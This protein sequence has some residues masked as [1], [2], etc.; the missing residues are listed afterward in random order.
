LIKQLPD[1]MTLFKQEL[2]RKNV[3]SYLMLFKDNVRI[4][5]TLVDRENLTD[6][7]QSDSLTMVLLDKDNLFTHINL[8]SEKDYFI[9]KPDQKRF[10]DCCNEFW[11]VST[12]VAKGL[13][14]N[15]ITYAKDMLEKP[16]RDMF[17]KMIEWYIGVKT[18]FTVSFGKSGKNMKKY[19]PLELYQRILQ[20]YPDH[21]IDNIWN[22][23][24]LMIDIFRNIQKEVS[25]MLGLKYDQTEE[26]NVIEYL[27]I[28]RSKH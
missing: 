3:F 27:K 8:P 25:D 20:T 21:K 26:D 7:L 11:W 22:S 17:M 10:S 13:C 2:K 9:K 19:I 12:Y 4:D 18:D 24:F 15:E 6:N 14:R 16:V 5:L 28:L 23:L 1:E